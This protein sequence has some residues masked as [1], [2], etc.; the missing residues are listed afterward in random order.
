[1]ECFSCYL[2]AKWHH[3]ETKVAVA[4][5]VRGQSYLEVFACLLVLV[6]RGGAETI[7]WDV[8]AHR[9]VILCEQH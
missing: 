8:L 4:A 1:M 6:R 5:I 9:D 7:E 2:C 3:R